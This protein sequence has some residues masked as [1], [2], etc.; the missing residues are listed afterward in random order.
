MIRGLYTSASGMMAQYQKMDVITNNLANINTTGY[1]KDQVITASF[2][3]ELTKRLNDTP[4]GGFMPKTQNIGRMSLGVQ[5][6]E[7]YTNFVQGSLQETHQPLDLALHGQGFFTVLAQEG[8]D[9]VERYTRDGAFLLDP[10]GRMVT[11]EGHRVVGQQGEIILPEGEITINEKGE[12]FVE[13]DYVDQ[14]Q[15]VSFDDLSTLQ[16]IGDNLLQAEGSEPQPFQ[17]KVFQG[18]LESS[19]VNPVREMV[20]MITALRVYEA[21]QKALQAQDQTLEK[22]INEAGRV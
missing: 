13:G 16:K 17:G 9:W 12:I 7:I 18:F 1:K 2:A 21:S 19:N 22:I 15:L 14:V 8:N 5:V 20:E 11:T 4:N 3:E 6:D 10:E